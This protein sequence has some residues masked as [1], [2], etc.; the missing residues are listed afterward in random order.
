MGSPKPASAGGGVSRIDWIVSPIMPM[1]KTDVTAMTHALLLKCRFALRSRKGRR[2]RKIIAK[3]GRIM[4]WPLRKSL[5]L[6]KK[7][8]SE[9]VVDSNH[10]KIEQK[11]CEHIWIKSLSSEINPYFN[12]IC[13]LYGNA[14][15]VSHVFLIPWP[16][17]GG[18]DL[19]T[20]NYIN[21]LS[22]NNLSGNIVVIATNNVESPWK[23]RLPTNVRF[24]AWGEKYHMVSISDQENLLTALLFKKKPKIV[25][26]INSD[27]GFKVFIN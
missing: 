16:K 7:Y 9:K 26:N 19:E 22:D 15:D 27:L 18:S 13:H 2:K 21:T 17:R 8:Y 14:E 12:E 20:I 5:S 4:T 10:L 24:I 6:L 25:H 3:L 1:P 11:P 23:E